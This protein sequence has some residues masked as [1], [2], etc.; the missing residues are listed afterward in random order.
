M[1][2]AVALLKPSRHRKRLISKRQL[3]S[4]LVSNVVA[5]SSIVTWLKT[6]KLF[7]GL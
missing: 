4:L 2:I 7:G 6:L 5:M 3:I 1:F